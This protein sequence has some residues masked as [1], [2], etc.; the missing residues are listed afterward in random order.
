MAISSGP[1][2]PLAKS[3]LLQFFSG[4]SY[5]WFDMAGIDIF[6]PLMVVA[7]LLLGHEKKIGF[8]KLKGLCSAMKPL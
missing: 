8:L 1:P 4:G 2:L 6:I 7:N 3:C 5:F